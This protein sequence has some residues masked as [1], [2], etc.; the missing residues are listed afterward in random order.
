M[1]VLVIGDTHCPAM[2]PG[3]VQFLVAMQK[4]WKCR[5]VI[6]I[7]DVVDWAGMGYHERDPALPAA[8]DEYHKAMAQ[9]QQLYAAF[10]R[11]TVLT[12]NHDD[13]PARQARSSG[14]PVDLLRSYARIWETPKWQWLPRY[15]TYV[16]DGVTYAHGDR[17][18]GGQ[19][20]ALKNAKENFTPWVQ[21]HLHSQA[22]CSYYANQDAIVFG[23]STGCGVDHDT[24]AMEYGKKFT[25]KPVIGCGV[26]LG[27]RQALFEP[28]PLS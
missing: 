18:K 11:C 5:K 22:G 17:G 2:L 6:H 1:N 4:R 14:I 28:M 9:V 10:P 3:Y 15:A 8:G 7:G 20:A 13:L 24:M 26:V 21:G 25:A 23:L 27:G 16:Y 19:Q 12:G